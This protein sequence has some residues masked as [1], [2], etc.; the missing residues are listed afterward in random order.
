M[1]NINR[2]MIQRILVDVKK[3]R[4]QHS[5]HS[6][7][8]KVKVK[9]VLKYTTPS[10]NPCNFLHVF[11]KRFN[12]YFRPPELG[13]FMRKN[14]H[15]STPRWK[16]TMKFHCGCPGIPNDRNPYL[17]EPEIHSLRKLLRLK[18]GIQNLVFVKSCLH[19]KLQVG[20][21]IS[22]NFIVELKQTH[23]RWKKSC[24]SCGCIKPCNLFIFTRSTG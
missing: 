17:H 10:N 16:N 19:L 23:G 24:T 22:C 9:E 14:A 5:H 4:L 18:K 11:F 6:I 20:I 1:P 7:S 15:S 8:V 3:W 13:S 2:T 12:G 21:I